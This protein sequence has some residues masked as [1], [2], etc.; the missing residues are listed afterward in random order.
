MSKFPQKIYQNWSKNPPKR[1]PKSTKI[2]RKFVSW[3][4]PEGIMLHVL[5]FVFFLPFFSSGWHFAAN[6]APSW[7]QVGPSWE[8]VGPSWVQDAPCWRQV[9]TKIAQVGAKMEP[10]WASRGIVW[11]FQW[12]FK[13]VS[14]F[15]GDFGSLFPPKSL[16]NL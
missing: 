5:F 4:G 12:I 2:N 15:H 13:F 1:L 7:P 10:T 11:R 6:L 9:G 8:Q 16:K 3:G 14:I